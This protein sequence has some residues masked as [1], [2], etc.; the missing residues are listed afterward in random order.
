MPTEAGEYSL[1]ISGV[2]V[3]LM[4]AQNINGKVIFVE[5]SGGTGEPNGTRSYELDLS[6][7]DDFSAAWRPVTGLQTDVFCSAGLIIPDIAERQLTVGGWAGTSSFSVRLYCPD[8]SACVPG[9]N[10]WVG[11]P[12]VLQFQVCR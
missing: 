2:V 3:P 4:T 1:L 7:I 5:K 6:R 11:D 12:G 9:T 8:G 10:E